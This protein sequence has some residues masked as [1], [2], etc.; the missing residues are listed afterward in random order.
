[1][2]LAINIAL[3]LFVIALHEAGHM[4][5]AWGCGMEVKGLEFNCR[6]GIAT[7][8]RVSQ[9]P[10]QNALT[11]FGGPLFNFLALAFLPLGPAWVL[12]NLIAALGNL[13]PLPHSDGSQIIFWLRASL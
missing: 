4:A 10:V 11:F 3:A 1:M 12:M 13:A 8:I 9:D 5:V 2:I 6:N 7:R